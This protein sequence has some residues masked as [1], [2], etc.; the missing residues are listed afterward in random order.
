[1]KQDA[2][3]QL[4]SDPRIADAVSRGTQLLDEFAWDRSMRNASDDF[5]TF[6]RRSC[7][8]ASAGL[9]GIALPSSALDE[10]D[11]SAMGRLANLSLVT[12]ANADQLVNTFSHSPFQVW[13]RLHSLNGDDVERGTP[14]THNDV[15]DVLHLGQ[16]PDSS[17]V[18]PRLTTLADLIVNSSAPA[19]LVSALAHA[20]MAVLRPFVHGSYLLARVTGRLVL[21]S[22]SLDPRGLAGVEIGLFQH[23]R[24]AYA[25]SLRQYCSGDLEQL[26][27]YVETFVSAIETGLLH[28]RTE[29]SSRK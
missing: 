28:T 29:F 2:F 24:P 4:A 6:M 27:K 23:G 15:N 20:E 8:Y 1:M 13:A 7:A 14:R 11:S 17:S 18:M 26:A 16:L 12:T 9:E 19:V 5:V 21:M 10:P 22:R 3:A 25:Q